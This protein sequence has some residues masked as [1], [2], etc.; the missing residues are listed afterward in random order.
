MTVGRFYEMPV[1]RR[2]CS[3]SWSAWFRRQRWKN[4]PFVKALL[5]ILRKKWPVRSDPIYSSKDCLTPVE[6]MCSCVRVWRVLAVLATTLDA[7]VSASFDKETRTVPS[8]L[9]RQPSN[10]RV[11]IRGRAFS[12]SCMVEMCR[13][14][15]H[16]QKYGRSIVRRWNLL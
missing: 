5:H 3:Y 12:L 10:V 9:G 6:R 4:S 15:T 13:L 2:L 14:S 7:A 8:G 11:L 16:D 1:A